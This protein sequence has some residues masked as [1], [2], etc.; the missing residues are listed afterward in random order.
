M[1]GLILI[2]W[3]IYNTMRK[4]VGSK[5]LSERFFLRKYLYILLWKIIISQSL[6]LLRFLIFNYLKQNWKQF[7]ILEER[8]R[9][10]ISSTIKLSRNALSFLGSF[11][12]KI[13]CLF[14]YPT[15]LTV[16]TWSFLFSI[17]EIVRQLSSA[18]SRNITK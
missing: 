9:S 4:T 7:L 17:F 16:K 5:R 14:L 6:L 1:P 15:W 18:A 8:F 2:Y 12:Q 10:T 3:F 13:I 11:P